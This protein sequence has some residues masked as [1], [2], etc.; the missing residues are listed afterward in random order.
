MARKMPKKR[1][2]AP[3]SFSKTITT[4]AMPHIAM[5]GRRYGIGGTRKRPIRRG[6][7]DEGPRE[8][9]E[10]QVRREPLDEHQTDRGERRGERKEQLVAAE[11]AQHEKDVQ[12]EDE[13]EV[14]RRHHDHR[15][16]ERRR[17]GADD[18]GEAR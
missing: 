15:R 16:P 2:V 5:I 1:S 7:G 17:F 10:E 12:R 14:D 8:L 11:A 6:A 18:R 13:T 3:R 4:I 9:L